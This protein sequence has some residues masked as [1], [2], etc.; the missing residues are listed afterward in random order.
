MNIDRYSQIWVP[1]ICRQ[2]LYRKIFISRN[3]PCESCVH[4]QMARAESLNLHAY[5]HLCLLQLFFTWFLALLLGAQICK[6][7][8]RSPGIDSK[9]SIPPAYV[10]WRACTTNRIVVSAR[11]LCSDSWAPEKFKNSGAGTQLAGCHF[12]HSG[13]LFRNFF[14]FLRQFRWPSKKNVPFSAVLI[15][16]SYLNRKQLSNW[17]QSSRLIELCL[18]SAET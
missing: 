10:T 1:N 12:H 17:L 7:F 4:L 5:I 11:F 6:L 16:L 15:C 2:R 14:S 3:N 8:L 9:E 13:E 18:L